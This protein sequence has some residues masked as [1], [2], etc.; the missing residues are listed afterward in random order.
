[1]TRERWLAAREGAPGEFTIGGSDVATILGWN[2]FEDPIGLYGRKLGLIE[3]DD[4][5]SEA[6]QAGRFLEGGILEWY[7]QRTGREVYTPLQL[8]EAVDECRSEWRPFA[9]DGT[10]TSRIRRILN[11]ASDLI[12]DEV[13]EV[14]YGPDEAG[15]VIFRVV[16]SPWRLLTPDAFVWDERLGWGI[17]DAKN[18]HQSK[19][20]EWSGGVPP[21]KSPQVAYY[22]QPTPFRWGGFAVVF[23]GQRLASYDMAR[24]DM[25]P[26]FDLIDAEVPAF[27]EALERR[28]QPKAEPSKKSLEALKRL[29]PTPTMGKSVAWV[30]GFAMAD[31]SVVDPEE[32][33]VEYLE[34]REQCREWNDRRDEMT[35]TIRAVAKDAEFVVMRGGVRYRISTSEN[36]RQQVRRYGR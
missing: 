5:D 22:T 14:A 12:L 25:A 36:G 26:I 4:T 23:G 29:Y 30:S 16:G 9:I 3:R 6:A 11:L 17:V 31:G 13:L 1:M 27:L 7:A 24:E 10:Y 18:L 35:A 2:D 32:F 15:R 21:D 20:R 33:D 8:A 34:V 19:A 28:E